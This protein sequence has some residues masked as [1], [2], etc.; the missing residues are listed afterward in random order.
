M[1]QSI[2][3]L[4]RNDK[5]TLIVLYCIVLHLCIYIALLE[6]H[7]NQKRLYVHI[8]TPSIHTSIH[9]AS[10]L[11]APKR[12]SQRYLYMEAIFLQKVLNWCFL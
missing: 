8:I 7:T 1:N 11:D 3:F 6:V 5:A 4:N 10:T 12:R 9:M 2:L